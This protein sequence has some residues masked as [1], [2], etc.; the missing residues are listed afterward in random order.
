[1]RN[2][3]RLA[4]MEARIETLSTANSFA[5]VL[6]V[7]LPLAFVHSNSLW[8]ERCVR[9]RPRTKIAVRL[10]KCVDSRW[11]SFGDVQIVPSTLAQ[12]V[13]TSD[14]WVPMPDGLVI[15]RRRS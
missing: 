11:H 1:M 6:F 12:D 15:G 3:P 4:A 5:A 2:T 7:T 10:N 8:T 9:L 14:G 13:V